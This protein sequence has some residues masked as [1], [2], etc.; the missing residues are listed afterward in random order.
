MA[1][2]FRSVGEIRHG[3][4]DRLRIQLR[5]SLQLVTSLM[6]WVDVHPCQLRRKSPT[7]GD[8]GKQFRVR[9][10]VLLDGLRGLTGDLFYVMAI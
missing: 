3:P 6:A 4:Q 7:A 2:F 9:G 10:H 1:P 8:L 5:Y